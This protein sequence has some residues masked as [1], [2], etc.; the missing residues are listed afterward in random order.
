MAEL[1][2]LSCYYKCSVVLPHG[3]LSWFHVC[4][5]GIS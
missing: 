4:D 5:C 1:S 2:S 3:A